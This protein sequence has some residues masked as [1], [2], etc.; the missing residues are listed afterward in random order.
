MALG[1]SQA[2]DTRGLQHWDGHSGIL[3]IGAD[4]LKSGMEAIRQG[5]LTAT[6]DVGGV[7]QGLT[8]IDAVF[9]SLVLGDA[10]DQV[11]NVATRVVDKSNVDGPEA[12]ISWALGPP[13][14][15]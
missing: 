4:G 12:Y 6:V 1:A 9:H 11:I 15:Y 8:F 3:T 7:D 10:V 2:I 13:K 5:K 14:T